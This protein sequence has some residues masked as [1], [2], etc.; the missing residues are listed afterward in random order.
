MADSIAVNTDA[1][2]A[3]VR[4]C[5][6]NARANETFSPEQCA[7]FLFQGKR[8][9]GL[10]VNLISATFTTPVPEV[11]EANDQLDALVTRLD[12]TAETLQKYADTIER[13]GEVVALLDRALKFATAV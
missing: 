5:F 9:R 11:D 1:L 13:I 7:E 4:L 12:D 2:S 6:A 3:A 10:L 8:L